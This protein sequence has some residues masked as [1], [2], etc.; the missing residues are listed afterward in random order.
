MSL[1]VYTNREDIPKGMQFINYNDKFFLSTSLRNDKFSGMVMKK[2]DKAEFHSRDTFIG[3][4]K[5][6]GALNKEHLSTGC[7]TLLNI[8]NNS[9][10]CFDVMECGQNALELLPIITEGN[11]LWIN[12]VLHFIG[13]A[14]CDIIIHDN[15][16]TAFR[17]FLQYIMD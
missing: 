16:F 11:I 2:I 9:D 5:S 12:P 8:I 17:K 13:D 6:L 10:K 3:R 15:R 1:N 14:E 7:K 4:D